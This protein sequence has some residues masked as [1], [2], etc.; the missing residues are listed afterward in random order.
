LASGTGS[1]IE[2]NITAVPTTG[3]SAPEFELK[4]DLDETVRLSDFRGKPLVVYF[5]P[6][7]DTPGCTT[8]A[9]EIRDDFSRF[10]KE[11]VAVLGVSPDSAKSHTRFRKKYNLP[12]HLLADE[13]HKVAERYGAWG[14]KKRFGKEYMGI[15]RTTFLIGADGKIMRIFENVHPE[16]HSQ[17]I[18]SALHEAKAEN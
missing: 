13:G 1:E 2:G 11:G 17:E 15:K 5:Y 10:H 8:E 14:L 16:G 12:F 6:K 18:L 7:D 3:E 4:N 9:C